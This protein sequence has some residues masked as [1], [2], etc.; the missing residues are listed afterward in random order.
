MKP[1]LPYRT[2]MASLLLGCA[3]AAGA[4]EPLGFDDPAKQ[5]RYE[6]LLQEIRCLVCQ[7]ESL[8][9]SGAGLADD[10]R[11]EIHRMVEQGRSDA[12]IR[13][14]LVDRYGDFVLYRPPVTAKTYLLWFG[15]ILLAAIGLLAL[16]ITVRRRAGAASAPDLDPAERERLRRMLD[17]YRDEQR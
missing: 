1:L 5:E 9:S 10:L 12:E 13:Q 14:Y 3:L 16:V 4:V 6:T 15:P 2:L 8:A 7:N 11:G 17:K